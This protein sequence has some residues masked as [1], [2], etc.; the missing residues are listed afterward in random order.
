V[1]LSAKELG[2]KYS[3]ESSILSTSSMKFKIRSKPTLPINKIGNYSKNI[4]GYSITSILEFLNERGVAPKD[5]YVESER[6]YGCYYD[7]STVAVLNYY[8]TRASKEEF[9]HILSDYNKKLYAYNEWYSSNEEQI[10]I[11]LARR[12]MINKE[13]AIKSA[14]RQT[15]KKAKEIADLEKR[16]SK[17]K[18]VK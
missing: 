1:R 12:E 15:Q 14:E 18:K 4:E 11:E 16:L 7:E 5:A 8:G 3:P 6:E 17:L 9:D 2:L 10:K 13:R